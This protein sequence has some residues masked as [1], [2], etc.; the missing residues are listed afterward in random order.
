MQYTPL[1]LHGR[2]LRPDVR[3]MTMVCIPDRKPPTV[4]W[5]GWWYAVQLEV[6]DGTDM[7]D[8]QCG[9]WDAW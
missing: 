4:G 6:V 7:W 2:Q 5:D 3:Q 9:I 8:R 1:Y